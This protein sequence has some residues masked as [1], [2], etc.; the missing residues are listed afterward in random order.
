NKSSEWIITNDK[1][2]DVDIGNL[3]AKTITWNKIKALN[4]DHPT[5]SYIVDLTKLQEELLE[6]IG[7]ELYEKIACI[8]HRYTLDIPVSFRDLF[9]KFYCDQKRWQY[10]DF[11]KINDDNRKLNFYIFM[12]DVCKHIF[13]LWDENIREAH[14][15]EG[16]WNRLVLDSILNSITHKLVSYARKPDFWFLVEVA[17][18]IQEVLLEETS[19]GPFVNDT[20]KFH[21]D[22]YK[23][24]RFGHDAKI[25]METKLISENAKYLSVV[26]YNKLQKRLCNINLFLIQ[27]Y[28]TKLRVFIMDQPEQPLCRVREIYNLKIPYQPVDKESVLQF[29]YSLWMTR[30]GLEELVKEI[31]EIGREIQVKCQ[32]PLKNF[33]V[34]MSNL[35]Y[36]TF[37]S[38]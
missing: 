9:E 35:E 17:G 13:S 4:Y 1:G 24:F 28:S 31:N 15:L 34:P 12:R 36:P 19:G 2:I 30:L 26:D 10:D 22:R 29:I 8:S 16:T 7:P 32:G 23:L 25:M 27:A 20:D 21:T 11:E 3:F 5:L 14:C 6:N 38:P 18:T 37:P 33:R